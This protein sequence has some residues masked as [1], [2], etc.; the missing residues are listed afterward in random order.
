MAKR[1]PAQVIALRQLG[2]AEVIQTYDDLSIDFM[3]EGQ[4]LAMG[5]DG[6][7]MSPGDY[8]KKV[9][10]PWQTKKGK[11]AKTPAP[12]IFAY[13]SETPCER[14]PILCEPRE[15]KH[16]AW[17]ADDTIW[18]IKPYGIA[19]NITGKLTLIDP[20]TVVEEREPYKPSEAWWKEEWPPSLEPHDEGLRF[21]YGYKYTEHNPPYSG[22][23][24]TAEE[25]EED[26]DFLLKLQEGSEK[27]G[28][29]IA[30]KL[31]VRFDGWQQGIGMQFTDVKETGASFYAN[32]E[33]EAKLKL[34]EKRE[35]FKAAEKPPDTAT[36]VEQIMAELTDELTDEHKATLGLTGQDVKLMLTS[37]TPIRKLKSEEFVGPPKQPIAKKTKKTTYEPQKTYIHLMPGYRDLL[38]KLK[39][40][41]VTNSI[42]S[43]NTKDSVKR[44]IAK[45]GLTDHY[46]E[47]RDSYEKKGKVFNEQMKEF[48]Y[49]AK[50][51][52]FVDNTKS[53]VEEVAKS[54]AI[55]LVYGVD[56]KDVAGI[57]EYMTNA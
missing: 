11:K 41:G 55:P 51:A 29:E 48:G 5:P 57:V 21:K 42:I 27:T 26:E 16:V 23:T 35:L 56:I 6:E 38:D 4:K 24:D 30:A 13:S 2:N 44:I 7:I 43:L 53:H 50:D 39:K 54:G 40:D 37:S 46:L 31:G 3:F 22:F 36:E 10:T 52:M 47:I 1:T 18:D 8:L 45:F 32:M 14:N 20:D 28:R 9:Y 25:E 17:D 33:M 12:S 34:K 19:G 49:K 15:I